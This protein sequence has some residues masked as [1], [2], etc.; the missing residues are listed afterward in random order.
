MNSTS[1]S[2][3][4]FLFIAPQMLVNAQST[5]TRPCAAVEILKKQVTNDPHLADRLEEMERTT[6]RLA[7]TALVETRSTIVIPVVVHVLYATN[8]QN[9]SDAQI[10]SQI[11]VLNRD[12]RKMNPDIYQIPALFSGAA[13]DCSIQFKLATRD[14]QGNATTGIQRYFTKRTAWNTNDE[15]KRPETGG[16]A[17]WNAAGYLNFWV[18]NIGDGTLGYAQFPGSAP[19]TDGVVI[20]YRCFGTI[21]TVNAPYNLGRTATHEV[22]HYFNLQHIWGDSDCGDDH[23]ADTPTQFKPNAGV[24]TFP[25]YSHCNNVRTVDMSM[26][27]M[28]YVFDE[29]MHLFTQGQKA[30]MQAVLSEEGLRAGLVTSDGCKAPAGTICA[31][32]TGLTAYDM[33]TQTAILNWIDWNANDNYRLEYWEDNN[34]QNII[35]TQTNNTTKILTGL[36]PNTTYS[37]R[38]KTACG[39]TWSEAQQ[40]ITASVENARCK[41]S[42]LDNKQMERAAPLTVGKTIHSMIVRAT[43]KDWFKITTTAVKPNVKVLLNQLPTDYDLK[44]YDEAGNLLRT[45]SAKGRKEECLWYNASASATYYVQ[46]FG[47]DGAFDTQSCYSL[48]YNTS[49][50]AFQKADGTMETNVMMA[51]KSFEIYPNPV[52]GEA[53]L[54]VNIEKDVFAAVKVW[55]LGGSLRAELGQ[56]LVKGDTKIRL[57]VGH[58]PSGLYLVSMELDGR[59]QNRKMTVQ[60]Y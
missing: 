10:L 42:G 58:L 16:V 21:G 56:N 39:A 3:I 29:A 50:N 30:R 35:S 34:N 41:D 57:E 52:V 36:T 15:M 46:I 13:V 9:I 48:T 60:T 32:P 27:F 33:T 53:I 43:D 45:S 20:D 14:P 11:A 17:P 51:D 2:M 1:F 5:A 47:Y 26:N 37:Y 28:D 44:L 40:F 23:V 12:F 31:A 49:A 25:H 54:E 24:P 6:A 18:C 22:G 59:I 7:S 19:E 38:V 8:I 55:D 4:L